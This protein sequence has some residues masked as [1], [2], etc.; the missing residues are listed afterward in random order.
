ML[1]GLLEVFLSLLVPK[2]ACILNCHA[3]HYTYLSAEGIIS[4]GGLARALTVRQNDHHFISPNDSDSL[5]KISLSDAFKDHFFL[6]E[7]ARL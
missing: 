6:R 3:T 1:T 4:G 2:W 5:L 7:I